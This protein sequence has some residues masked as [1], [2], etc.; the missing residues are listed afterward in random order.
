VIDEI[1]LTLLTP[2][3]GRIGSRLRYLYY[4]YKLKHCG[5][6]F[7]SGAGF[8]MSGYENI[9][10]GK[11]CSFNRGVFLGAS[12]RIHIGDD[13]MIGAYTC[14][15]DMDHGVESVDIPMRNQKGNTGMIIIGNDVWIGMQCSVLR[16]AIIGNGS[17]IGANSLVKK[18]IGRNG[19]WV[20][21][22]AR[23]LRKR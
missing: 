23:L 13:V 15:R 4:K 11:R 2:I 19:I 20:G 7:S 17:V 21:S 16:G 9:S 5:G 3:E 6:Y 1:L 8:M 22:P 18:D 10:I 14:M 12:R